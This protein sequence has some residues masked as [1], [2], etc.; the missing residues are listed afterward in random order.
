[1]NR[2][3]MRA[4]KANGRKKIREGWTK[5]EP[6]PCPIGRVTDC[7]E[8]WTNSMYVVFRCVKEDTDW[9]L[10]ERLMIRRND[11]SSAV[12]WSDMQRIK[13]ELCG[14]DKTAIQVYP[15]ASEVVDFA[16]IYHLWVLPIGFVLPFSLARASK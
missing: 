3:L 7:Y 1:M 15:P 16:N 8:T 10:V 5:F 2:H 4:S 13:N 6:G 14:K 12:S 11:E 9:G